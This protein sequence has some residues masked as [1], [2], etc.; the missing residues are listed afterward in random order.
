[1]NK[2]SCDELSFVLRDDN[3]LYIH[4]YDYLLVFIVLLYLQTHRGKGFNPNNTIIEHF[5]MVRIRFG[6]AYFETPSHYRIA[7][8]TTVHD[9][10]SVSILDSKS[11]PEKLTR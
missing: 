11:K 7:Q 10:S 9:F 4:P 6:A 1:M 3:T 5:L 8:T 2:L